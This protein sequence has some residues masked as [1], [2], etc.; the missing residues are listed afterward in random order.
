MEKVRYLN[1]SID[2]ADQLIE[3]WLGDDARYA[4]RPGVTSPPYPGIGLK[5]GAPLREDWFP[6]VWRQGDGAG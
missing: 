5:D 2:E 4:A 1:H 3:R 6:V